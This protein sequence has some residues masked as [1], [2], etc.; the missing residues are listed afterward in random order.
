LIFGSGKSAHRAAL[1]R[2]PDG[3][4]SAPVVLDDLRSDLPIL[5]EIRID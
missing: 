1:D 2:L 5:P 4:L 3:L